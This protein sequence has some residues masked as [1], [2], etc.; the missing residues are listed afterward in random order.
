MSSKDPATELAVLFPD[1]DLEVRDPDTGEAVALTV[2][3][4]RFLEGLRAQALAGPFVAA[5]AEVVG[6]GEEDALEPA[7]VAG[8]MAEHA[9]TW[10]SLIALATD[11]E[12]A[13]VARLR[14]VDADALSEAMWSA[15]AGFFMRR[16]VAS[17]AAAR[18]PRVKGSRSAKSSTPSSGQAT[19]EGT[20]SSPGA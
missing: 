15:N 9:K 4:F 17:V 1:V 3:E 11:R 8:L 18:N 5:L 16:V 6:T 13:W 19:A 10:L 12:L 7:T 2:R 20:T 14:D